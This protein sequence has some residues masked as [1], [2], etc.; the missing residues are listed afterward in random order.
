MDQC[1]RGALWDVQQEPVGESL[2][3]RYIVCF[4][5]MVAF[6]PA[7]YLALEKAW[8][9]AKW[10]KSGS[11][12][13]DGVNLYQRVDHRMG[14]LLAKVGSWCYSRR[15][16]G[17]HND[18]FAPFHHIERHPYDGGIIAEKV[19]FWR[20][21]KDRV[22]LLQEAA[23]PFHVVR[24]WR[25]WPKR[26]TAQYPFPGADLE[27]VGQVRG[28]RGKLSHLQGA[29]PYILD[30]IPQVML[31]LFEIKVLSGTHCNRIYLIIHHALLQ[32]KAILLKILALR[33]YNNA[34]ANSTF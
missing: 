2:Y 5:A 23:L 27:Q 14:D 6:N 11:L 32:R 34:G 13:V 18:P 21:W 7:F 24:F 16:R 31:D 26:R 9:M 1:R 20:K 19:R 8:R 22:D 28:A 15:K 17:I 10:I 25:Y 29:L 33:V 12:P 4:G 3:L 30:V